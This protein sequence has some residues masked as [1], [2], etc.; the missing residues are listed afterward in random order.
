MTTCKGGALAAPPPFSEDMNV[1]VL[2]LHM[3]VHQLAVAKKRDI[4][5]VP[6]SWRTLNAWHQELVCELL[7]QGYLHQSPLQM[8]PRGSHR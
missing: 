4:R 6:M 2:Q 3:L 8:Q 1:P 5:M 7:R